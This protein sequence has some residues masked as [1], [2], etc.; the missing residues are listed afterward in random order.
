M[1]SFFHGHSFVAAIAKRRYHTM[2]I[3][4]HALSTTTQLYS[5]S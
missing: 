1:F 2:R 3:I 4:K 5:R